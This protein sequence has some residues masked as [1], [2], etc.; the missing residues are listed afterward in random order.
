MAAGGLCLWSTDTL[1]EDVDFR[2]RYQT[3]Y[4][5]GWKAWMA[6]LSDLSAMGATP[7]GG[8]IAASVPVGTPVSALHALQLGAADAAAVDGAAVLGGD[9]GRTAG[10]LVLTVTVLGEIADGRAVPLG[11]GSAGEGVLVTGSLGLAAAALESLEQGSLATPDGWRERLLQP[12]SRVGA[13]IALRRAGASAMTDVSDGL[14]LDLTRLC[15]ASGVGA[16]LWLDRLPVEPSLAAAGRGTELA[17][18]GGDDFELLATVPSHLV[19]DLM[20]GWGR[21]GPSLTHVGVLTAELGVR[22]RTGRR[23]ELVASPASD[24]FRHF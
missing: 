18:T 5:V 19:E 17:L 8:L 13:G 20:R 15:Q 1:V 24:G 4:Q 3:P 7:I 10:P 9:L 12:G 22:L 11:G 23:G 14:L 16:E 2:R 6:S 21:D